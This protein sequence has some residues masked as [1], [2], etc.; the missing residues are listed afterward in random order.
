MRFQH[1]LEVWCSD[2]CDISAK[3]LAEVHGGLK[4]RSA[5]LI[6]QR[7]LIFTR[8]SATRW[9]APRGRDAGR[10]ARRRPTAPLAVAVA[11]APRMQAGLSGSSRIDPRDVGGQRTP[12]RLRSRQCVGSASRQRSSREKPPSLLREAAAGFF[13]F[14]AILL[15]AVAA[16]FIAF[17]LRSGLFADSGL[18]R[19]TVEAITKPAVAEPASPAIRVSHVPKSAD[20]DAPP[21]VERVVPQPG[22]EAASEHDQRGCVCKRSHAAFREDCI[23][24]PY[25]QQ[26]TRGRRHAGR[27]VELGALDGLWAS[28]TF[29]LEQCLGWRGLL[30]E[31]NPTNFANLSTSGRLARKVHSAVCSGRGTIAFAKGKGAFSAAPATVSPN[32]IKRWGKN[33]AFP[34]LADTV[35]VPCQSLS[36][37]LQEAGFG[38]GPIDFLSLDVE[39]AEAQVLETVD[40]SVFQ[41]VMVEADGFNRSKE[42]RVA[43]LLREGGLVPANRSLQARYSATFVQAN[44]GWAAR[45]QTT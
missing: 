43:E 32:M 13:F 3:A 5:S 14:C 39:G 10:P 9:S 24:M 16:G 20:H 34:D 8:S 23:A 27:F 40:T 28:N 12:S 45:P 44:S 15:L 22:A 11:A 17:F 4:M 30:I 29:A 38:S 19:H 42:A 21:V 41:M 1:A 35:A 2:A 33:K 36:S 31:A 6:T 26:V 18:P 37:L 25:L 7:L